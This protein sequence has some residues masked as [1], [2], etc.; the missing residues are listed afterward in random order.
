MKNS[1]ISKNDSFVFYFLNW[2]TYERSYLKREIEP[3][4][5]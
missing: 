2:E 5:F 1:I 4:P 3:E